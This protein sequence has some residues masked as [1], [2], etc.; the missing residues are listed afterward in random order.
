MLHDGMR[1]SSSD[2]IVDINITCDG[3]RRWHVDSFSSSAGL[4]EREPLL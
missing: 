3:Y 4:D 1:V 2:F